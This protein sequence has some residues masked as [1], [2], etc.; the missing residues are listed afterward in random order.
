M[1]NPG[2]GNGKSKR[3][4]G[5]I[6]S[7]LLV[8]LGDDI[9]YR[10]V[11]LA[12]REMRHNVNRARDGLSVIDQTLDHR[13]DGIIIGMDLPE[14]NGLDVARALRALELTRRIPMLFIAQNDNEVARIAQAALPFVDWVTAPLN[15]PVFREQVHRLLH[16]D[17]HPKAGPSGGDEALQ[18]MVIADPLTGLYERH[19]LVH[20]LTY[21]AM[22][23]ARYRIT[24]ACVAFAIDGYDKLVET[25][26]RIAM[27]GYVLQAANQIRRVARATDIVGHVGRDK[28]LV[29]MPH[30]DADGARQL[31]ER[32][33]TLVRN[34][35]SQLPFT[36]SAGIAAVPG[37]N[38]TENLTLLARSADALA[39]AQQNGV[40]QIAIEERV[41]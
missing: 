39:H 41:L 10:I 33:Q 16:A 34:P 17:S 12:L 9:S 19:Y 23:A 20:R 40:N 5:V 37:T 26:G 29:I 3:G 36:M 32:I 21:E 35:D 27:D 13:P 6:S 7:L 15:I 24:L 22:R 38:I 1:K 25:G 2:Y 30:A 18:A 31:A 4:E 8:A 28:F 14:L 11:E